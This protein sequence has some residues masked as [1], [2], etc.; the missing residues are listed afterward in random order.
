MPPGQISRFYGLNNVSDPLR[1]GAK[2][3]VR[4][5]NI[6]VTDTGGITKRVGYSKAF[7]GTITGA[8]ST[9]DYAR[10]YVV[11]G[12]ALKS[13]IGNMAGTTLATGLS[14][15][16]MYWT[17][18]NDSVFFNN[19][20]DRG[21]IQPDNVVMDW[22]WPVPGAPAVSATTGSL[23]PGV[24]QVRCTY[25]LADGRATGA[26]DSAT[27]LL[28]AGQALQI[29]AIPKTAGATTNVYIAPADSTVFQYAGS[30]SGTA[31]GW[32]ASPDALGVDLLNNFLDPLPLGATVIQVWR[33]RI[34]AAQY[35]A[36][37]DQT[38]VWF[39]QPLQHHL[40]NLNSNFFLVPGHV[41]MLAPHD[42]ALVIGT[43]NRVYTYDGT[44]LDRVAQYGV[45]PGWHWS[46]DIDRLLFWTTRGLCSFAPFTNLTERQVSVPPGVSAGGTVMFSRGQKRYV[47]ALK[48]GGSAFNPYFPT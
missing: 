8:F 11:D 15:A 3:L 25:T 36:D 6:D 5:D 35:F 39:T 7:T 45:A 4:A 40:F 32:N 38:A 2:W 24:Y 17:E 18:T 48:Q 30:P 47:V 34:Y 1:V 14:P 31:M 10:M 26:G 9:F 19:G 13:M 12:G 28:T 21:V 42:D 43:E 44:K 16:P 20:V 46:A 23:A 37:A 22:A 29:T 41:L 33:G 27:I